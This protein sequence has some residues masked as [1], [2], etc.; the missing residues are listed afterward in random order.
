MCFQTIKNIFSFGG[1]IF[2]VIKI[3]LCVLFVWFIFGYLNDKFGLLKPFIT[4]LKAVFNGI[5][6]AF[7]LIGFG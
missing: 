3:A 2:K 4:I 1:V 5:K 6:G 7:S